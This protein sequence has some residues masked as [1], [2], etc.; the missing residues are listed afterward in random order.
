MRPCIFVIGTRAQ[1]VKVA[2]VLREAAALN[3][4]HAVWLTGQHD[5]T[6][7]DLIN[8]L[9]VTSP[10]YSPPTTS[11]RST[12][13]GLLRWLPHAAID[14]YR[15]VRKT[16]L[17]Y[18]CRPLV[19]V[20][21][22]TLSTLVSA[23]AGK[24][25]AADIVH[26]ESGLTS[27]KIADPFPEEI[28]RR[29]TFRLTRYAICPN[30]VAAQRMLRYRCEEIL[31]TTENTLLD[32]VR[33]ALGKKPSADH[34]ERGSY[35]VASIHRVQ[36]LYHASRFRE[37]VSEIL[38]LSRF[39]RVHFVLHPATRRQLTSRGL[40]SVL[41]NCPA[42]TLQPRM[43]YTD[44]LMLIANARGVLTDGG[45]NQEELS[46]LGVPTLLYRERSERP[47]GLGENAILRHS[48][49]DLTE[50]VSSGRFDQLRVPRRLRPEVSPSRT[51]AQALLR[52]AEKV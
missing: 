20:H 18:T 8:D 14:C 30:E 28:L 2:P 3:L 13:L 9:E 24:A 12:V 1:M 29:L 44:F 40:W 25:A 26:L 39:G 50:F 27:G 32:C 6:I 45:S 42:I 16:S 31:H 34:D 11:E 17:Q 46:Y 51:A 37:I 15:Y 5:E 48:V 41:A 7:G 4:K 33:Y 35:F 49:T 52:W 10:L 22:D 19:I 21:G 38:E 47:D 43:P 36:N 23:L